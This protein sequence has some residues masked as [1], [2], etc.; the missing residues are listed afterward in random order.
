MALAARTIL[1]RSGDT[2]IELV[3]AWSQTRDPSNTLL[4]SISPSPSLSPTHLSELV[5][6][7]TKCPNNIGCL[8]SPLN[9][10]RMKGTSK[11]KEEL[12]KMLTL[13]GQLGEAKQGRRRYR[14][15]DQDK[16]ILKKIQGKGLFRGDGQ[17]VTVCSWAE[18]DSTRAKVFRSTIPGRPVTQVG[19]WHMARKVGMKD[20]LDSSNEGFIGEVPPGTFD[21]ESWPR[22]REAEPLPEEIEHTELVL[23]SRSHSRC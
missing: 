4:F 14:V 7:F 6:L 2:L 8:S 16:E 12:I 11:I 22:M 3:T 5:Q 20:G 21:G 19:R 15:R 10:E 23:F 13:S 17:D 18:F 9:L 1:S